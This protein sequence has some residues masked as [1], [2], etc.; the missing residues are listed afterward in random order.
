MPGRW[1]RPPVRAHPALHQPSVSWC[2]R[3]ADPDL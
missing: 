2:R 3:Y 1:V